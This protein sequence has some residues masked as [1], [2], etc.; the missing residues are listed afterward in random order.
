[1]TNQPPRRFKPAAAFACLVSGAAVI[2]SSL[3]SD[4]I[5]CTVAALLFVFV[6]FSAWRKRVYQ[7]LLELIARAKGGDDGC[8]PPQ[9]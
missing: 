7:L 5:T 8:H 2:I 4:W 3:K 9:A 1:M 6:L